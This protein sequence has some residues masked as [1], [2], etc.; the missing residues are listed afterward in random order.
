MIGLSPKHW[1]FLFLAIIILVRSKNK[2]MI[3]GIYALIYVGALIYWE[4]K[5]PSRNA[6]QEGIQ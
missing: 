3:L 1:L 5:H 2:K 4:N 6:I